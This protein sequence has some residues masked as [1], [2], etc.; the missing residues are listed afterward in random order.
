MLPD[1]RV[2]M[3][4]WADVNLDPGLVIVTPENDKTFNPLWGGMQGKKWFDWYTTDD[5]MQMSIQDWRDQHQATYAVLRLDQVQA[6]QA[7]DGG[8]MYLAQ[9]LH[10]RDFLGGAP[11]RGPE[12]VFY[13]LRRMDVTTQIVFDNRITLQGYDVDSTQV[14]PG[15]VLTMRFYWNASATPQDNYSLFV[16]L[17]PLSEETLVSQADGNPAVPERLTLTW[18]DPS[19]TLISPPF[20]VSIPAELPPGDYRVVIGLY[21]FQNGVRLPVTAPSDGT[22]LGNSIDLLHVTVTP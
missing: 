7:S 3:R 16:H 20:V 10:L 6:M 21:N 22:N 12:M 14:A 18:N 17:M 8:R 15:D 5:I 11:H 9:M 1:R 13:R 19:E 2:E 4:Y